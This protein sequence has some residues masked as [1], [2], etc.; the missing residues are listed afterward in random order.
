MMV[1]KQ[2]LRL[3]LIS[4]CVDL[5]VQMVFKVLKICLSAACPPKVFKVWWVI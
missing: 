1:V 2:L 5:C 4:S 3:S